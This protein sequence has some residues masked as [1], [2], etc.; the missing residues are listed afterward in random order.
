MHFYPFVLNLKDV[1]GSQ[2]AFG[3]S[4]IFDSDRHGKTNRAMKFE[5]NNTI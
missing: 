5:D 4:P 2:D 3:Y 1:V